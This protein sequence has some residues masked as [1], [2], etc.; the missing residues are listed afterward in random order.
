MGDDGAAGGGTSSKAKKKPDWLQR[1]IRLKPGPLR[2]AVLIAVALV[3]FFG[4]GGVLSRVWT[5]YLWYEEV[6]HTNVFW[7][8][9]LARLLV[10]L[11][12]AVVFFAVFYGSVWLARRISPRLLPVPQSEDGGVFEW[13]TTR[14]WPGRLMLSICIV[15]AIVIGI[16]YSARWEQVLLFLNQS[17]FGYRDPL[18]DKDASFFVFTL[19]LW[20]M[21]VN[22]TGI[23]LLFTFIA[24][25]FTYIVDRAL[26]VGDNNKIR[27]AA[28]VK[29]HL[30]AIMALAMLAKAADYMLQ[31]WELDYSTRGVTLGASYTDVNATLPVLQFL[32]IVSVVAAAIFLLNIRFKGWKLPAIAIAVM[33][34]TWALAGKAYPAI[35]QQ[36][37]VSPNEISAES[38]YIG[39]NIQATR[40]AFG[41]HDISEV[42]L[43]ADTDLTA[44]DILAN[45]ATIDNVR[46]WEPRPALS[47]YSQIQEIRLYYSFSDV[48][49]D[50]YVI[51]DEYRQ[52]LISARELDQTQLQQQSQ[53]WVNKHLTYT[54]GYGFVLSPVNEAGRDGLPLLF[55][56]NIPPTT[57]TDIKITRPE[58]YYGELGN[59]FVVVRT[60]SP[61]FDYPKGDTNVFTTY[62]GHGGIPIGSTIRQLAFSFRFNTLKILFSSSFTDESR[63]MYRRTLEERVQALAPFLSYDRDPYLVVRADGSLVWMWDAYTTTNRFP[64]S[65]PHGDGLNYIRNSIKVVIDAYNGGLT[66]YQMEGDDPVANAWG[67]IFDGLFTPGEEMPEDLRTHVR[68]PEDFY[69]IQAAVLSTY[70]MTDPQIF[71]NKEDVWEIPMEIYGQEEIPV[72]PY[73]EVLALPGETEPEFAL[74]Q[75][76]A[77]LSKMNM[78]ALLVARQD[79][80]NYGRLMVVDLPK[81]KLV[82]GPAQMEARI[83]NDPVI[84]SQI[85]LWSQAGSQVIR[86]NLLVVPVNQSVMYFEPVYLQAQQSPI[87]EL[88]RVIVG[89]GDDIVMEPTLTDALVKIFGPEAAPD[90]TTTTTSGTTTT[91]SAPPSTT[92]TTKP[93]GST[94]TTAEGPSTTLPAD[95]AALIELA[96][97]HYEAAIEAQKRGDWAEYGNELEELGKVLQALEAI[98]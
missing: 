79:G 85:T 3:L 75:P 48:D 32:A 28:H 69:S 9:I 65:Q 25:A 12:F 77:P 24:T 57:A 50:R 2:R 58:I 74:L 38:E 35:I 1:L 40:W 37:R 68:Y 41:L 55:V 73:Y 76:F 92:T 96:N 95:A 94:T 45:S 17:D 86:G 21:L 14:K 22:F 67:R 7:T 47:T 19:P 44:A 59:D 15:V 10:G 49:V 29:A 4:L 39:N 88:T 6:G 71:Y 81:S 30:S 8:P 11:F 97:Q 83:S 78:A 52:V 36:Y 34:L 33:I 82:Y 62:E 46:L 61:E 42:S 43:E 23:V 53:T 56:R 98:R 51:D 18:F 84:S 70:H 27:L 5:G 13:A 54:H 60:T 26:V 93:D 87:P 72:V 63:I 31:T 20:S 91:T 89:Y 90:A 80:E 66:F 64:Y 16:A